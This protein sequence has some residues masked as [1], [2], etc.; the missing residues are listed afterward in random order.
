MVLPM[1]DL[2]R[3]R[4]DE[5]FE[6]VVCVRQSGQFVRHSMVLL[7]ATGLMWLEFLYF[8]SDP[9]KSDW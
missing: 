4:V 1:M 5:R 8:T 2:H 3:H 9:G 6:S 7:T